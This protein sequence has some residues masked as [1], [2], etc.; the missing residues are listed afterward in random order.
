MQS[1]ALGV[2]RKGGA[3]GQQLQVP[4]SETRPHSEQCEDLRGQPARDSHCLP[5]VFWLIAS[6]LYRIAT[7]KVVFYFLAKAL[8]SVA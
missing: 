3:V 1:N 5:L 7:D 2:D 8:N 4:G 6:L